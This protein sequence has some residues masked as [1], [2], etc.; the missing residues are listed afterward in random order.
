MSDI[1]VKFGAQDEN[2][3]DTLTRIQS[4]L[5]RIENASE[6]TA[7]KM[8]DGFGVIAKGAAVAQLGVEAAM[9]AISLAFDAAASVVQGFGDAI[10]MGGALADLSKRTGESAGNLVTLQRAFENT[11]VGAEKVGPTINK[12]QKFMEKAS[13]ASSTQAG[14]LGELGTSYEELSGK[15]PIQQMEIFADRIASIDDPG[16]R[17]ATAMEVFGK[18]GGELLPVLSNFAGEVKGAAD[19]LGSLPDIMTRS[20]D[21]FDSAGDSMD[22][23]RSKVTEFAAGIL[24]KV[25]PAMTTFLEQLA[26]VDAAGWGQKL[27]DQI[28]NVADLLLGAF[29]SPMTAVEAIGAALSAHMR[30]VGNLYLNAFFTGGDFLRRFWTSEIP[31]YVL[32][33]LGNSLVEAYFTGIK[34]FLEKSD[35]AIQAVY[36]NFTSVISKI[37]EFYAG[38]FSRVFSV[39]GLDFYNLMRD[40]VQFVTQKFS[41]E[42][43]KATVDGSMAFSEG[44]QTASGGFIQKTKA[45]LDLVADG[46]GE[47]SQA[48]ADGI[49]TSFGKLIQE[50]TPSATDFF[51]A[52]PAAEEMKR[53]FGEMVQS[54]K[55]IREQFDA[56]NNAVKAAKEFM[57]NIMNKYKATAKVTSQA[58]ENAKNDALVV[59]QSLDNAGQDLKNNTG[60]A[61]DNM[62]QIRTLGDLIKA[63]DAAAP[64]KKFNEQ[65]KEARA[66]LKNLKDFIGGDFSRLSIPDIAKKLQIDTANKDQKELF[67]DIKK[68]LA[69]LKGKE[70]DIKINK[71]ATKEDLDEVIK[72]IQARFEI[73]GEG[74]PL[75]IN[76]TAEK[77]IVKIK[78]SL[79]QEVDLALSSSKGTNILEALKSAV[80]VIKTTVQAIEPKLPQTALGV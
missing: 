28:L 14:I 58:T 78:E 67:E 35:E 31:K 32:N 19:Q 71:D 34:F 3:S 79:K 10:E 30:N 27:G 21:T 75:E 59:K 76:M 38:V 23:I 46:F 50:T 16:K 47:K 24:D 20:S 11:G 53:K 77:S 54:G 49:R 33:F 12:L 70:V 17:A 68:K 40:P 73:F 69:D 80:D 5:G 45:G 44:Y 29:K 66:D 8:D 72:E 22:A 36:N 51:G 60:E 63:Q 43:V 42:L 55:Q 74:S 57:D 41:S 61:K 56:S 52:R 25:L 39:A 1:T 4:H 37:G 26:G 64:M 65:V 7:T 48:A 18:A 9:K 13:E 15:T 6:K 62:V 2:L